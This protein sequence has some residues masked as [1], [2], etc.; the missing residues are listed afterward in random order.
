MSRG[1][2][3]KSAS[4]DDYMLVAG[5]DAGLPEDRAGLPL[6]QWICIEM[7]NG[8]SVAFSDGISLL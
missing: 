3:L 4:T 7:S 8:F 2:A 5:A 6:V 1:F